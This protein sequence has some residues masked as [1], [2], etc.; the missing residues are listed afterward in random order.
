MTVATSVPRRKYF[1]IVAFLSIFLSA[2]KR[3]MRREL[4]VVGELR[5]AG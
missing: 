5:T 2:K 3:K 1:L 4:R